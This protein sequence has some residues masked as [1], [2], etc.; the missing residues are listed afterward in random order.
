ML[1]SFTVRF[2]EGKF[3][4]RHLTHA[5]FTSFNVAAEYGAVFVHSNLYPTTESIQGEA[6]AAFQVI[7]LAVHHKFQFVNFEG[8]SKGA[9][10]ALL[11][12]HSSL[13]VFS[14]FILFLEKGFRL[15]VL[16]EFY[17]CLQECKLFCRRM[18]LVRLSLINPDPLHFPLKWRGSSL[19]W[20]FFFKM[21]NAQNWATSFKC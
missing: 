16:L 5:S 18:W 12:L 4:C 1:V 6:Y 15:C 11:Q 8:D 19:R 10:E 2:G 7:K 13:M 14:S 20:G 9:I 3:R 17:F 21:I